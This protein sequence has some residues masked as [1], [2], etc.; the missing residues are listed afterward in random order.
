M[1]YLAH[2]PALSELQLA[3]VRNSQ[4][5]EFGET[6]CHQQAAVWRIHAFP[7]QI[8]STSYARPWHNAYG[9]EGP[10]KLSVAPL[11]DQPKDSAG[12]FYEISCTFKGCYLGKEKST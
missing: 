5:L 9:W 11:I 8:K 6:R 1:L 10:S 3:A 12:P 2:M 7:L 4:G